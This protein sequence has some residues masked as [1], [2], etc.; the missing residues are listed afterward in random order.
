MSEEGHH[1]YKASL[2]VFS[3]TLSSAEL[4]GVLGEPTK[5][6]D[7]GDA[8]TQRRPDAPKRDQAL[9]LLES[10]L[11]DTTPLDQHI[12]AVL[13]VIDAHREGLDAI[14]DQCEIDIFCGIFSGGGQGGFALEPHLSRRIAQAGL[15][16]IFDIY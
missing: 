2:R 5:S 9:W 14:R 3:R 10:G 13:D 12:A 6:H 11:E 15:A 4:T 8:V 7:A 1:R 16:V